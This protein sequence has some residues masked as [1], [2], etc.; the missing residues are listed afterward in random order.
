MPARVDPV[1]LHYF[2]VFNAW[3]SYILVAALGMQAARTAHNHQ[4]VLLTFLAATGPMF[5]EDLARLLMMEE[6]R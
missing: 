3:K 5:V 1:K 4:D 6:S 2:T